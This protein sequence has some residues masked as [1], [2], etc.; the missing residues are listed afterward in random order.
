MTSCGKI[1]VVS[2]FI[3]S[4][5]FAIVAGLFLAHRLPWNTPSA[6]SGA[7]APGLIEEH[8]KKIKDLV[9][10]HDRAIARW[11]AYYSDLLAL[12][13]ER[14]IRQALYARKLNTLRTSKDPGAVTAVEDDPAATIALQTHEPP[15]PGPPQVAGAGP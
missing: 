14:P 2:Q 13:A 15:Q 6:S 4:L 5:A 1:L 8:Q 9:V 7:P 11:N 3:L 10:A 12:E